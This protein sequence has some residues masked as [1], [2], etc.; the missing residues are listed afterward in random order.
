[1]DLGIGIVADAAASEP[2][3]P[4]PDGQASDGLAAPKP[5]KRHK[6]EIAHSTRGRVRLKIPG[7]KNNPELLDQLKQS[8]SGQPGVDAVETRL[9]TGSLLIYYDPNHHPDVASVFLN[10]SH[11]HEAAAHAAATAAVQAARAPPKTKLDELTREIEDEAE[12]LAEHSSVAK[13]IVEGAKSLD[14]QIKL[15]TNNNL[16]LKILLPIGLAGFT[17]LEIGAAAATPMW[18]TLLLFSLNH[19]VELHA[20][21]RD[22]PPPS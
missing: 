16:D 18:V 20:H 1:M 10:M 17:V 21:D 4:A 5:H 12:F 19:F 7:A 6:A 15:A 2:G 11:Q 8:F 9:A 22:E 3:R 13:A 14:R